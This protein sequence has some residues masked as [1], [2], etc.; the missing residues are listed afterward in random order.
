MLQALGD[1]VVAAKERWVCAS[2]CG[3]EGWREELKG[4]RKVGR[5][6][7]RTAESAA[8]AGSGARLFNKRRLPLQHGLQ[9]DKTP[10]LS[11]EHT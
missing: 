2:S 9:S 1:R 6:K 5:P 4:S 7:T 8:H 3:K 11:S 10:K